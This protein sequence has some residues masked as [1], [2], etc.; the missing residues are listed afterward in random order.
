MQMPILCSAGERVASSSCPIC[1]MMVSIHGMAASLYSRRITVSAL[2]SS[3]NRSSS[4]EFSSCNEGGVHLATTP[5]EQNSYRVEL[6]QQSLFI[7]KVVL[8][9][10]PPS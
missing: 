5:K 4:S 8:Q 2:A 6:T 7:A 3:S 9:S 10:P 1:G